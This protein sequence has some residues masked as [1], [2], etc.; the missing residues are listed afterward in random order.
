MGV[1]AVGTGIKTN[2]KLIRTYNERLGRS[3][4]GGN[5]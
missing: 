2:R 1:E 3:G 5:K 4:M